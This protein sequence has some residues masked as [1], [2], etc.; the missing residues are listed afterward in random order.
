MTIPEVIQGYVDSMTGEHHR[1]RS[2]EHCYE[3]FQS[4][5]PDVI[6]ADRKHAALQ[7]AFY[8]ANWGMYRGSSFLLRHAYTV[9]LAVV[10]QLLAPQFSVLW[11]REFGATGEDEV[12][13][14]TILDAANAVREAYRPFVLSEN[15]HQASDTLV[16]KVLL[17]TIGCLPACDRYCI[18]GFKSVGF[19]YSYLNSK[20]IR[21]I[22]CFCQDNLRDLRQEQTRIESQSGVY[23]PLMKLVDMY[24]WQTG[25]ERSRKDLGGG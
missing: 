18:Q 9:H 12:L 24:F 7:L 10:D 15:G 17:G 25:W 4:S 20:F 19:Q 8:L 22:L 11:M 6:A 16:T 14:P 5:T 21:R 3:Y 2:W 23:Y 1:Y 13:L